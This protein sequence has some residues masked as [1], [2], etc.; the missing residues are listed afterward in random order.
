MP[1]L[2]HLDAIH[3]SYP[4]R[5]TPVLRGTDL[6][7][8]P[9]SRLGLSGAN[10]SGKSTL[11]HI[12]AGLVRPQ[13]GTVRFKGEACVTEQDFAVFRLRLGYLLQNAEDQLFCPTVLEDVAFGPYNQGH[14]KKAA[15]RIARETLDELEL[16]HLAGLSGSNLSGG[17]K[18][19]AALAAILSMQPELLFLDEPTNDLDPDSRAKLLRI[20]GSRALP[21]VVIS[22]DW[23]FLNEACNDFCVL[24]DGVITCLPPVA[25]QHVHVHPAPDG[26]HSH[27]T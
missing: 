10:G 20:L 15:E 9:G 8:E 27:N 6:V 18:K 12:A 3:Y 13:A 14:D 26:G 2:L 1:P 24:R 11:L 21:C 19:M 22:H 23:D 16:A 4:G 5:S 7:L 17:E 25:H